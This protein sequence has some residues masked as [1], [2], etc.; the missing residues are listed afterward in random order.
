MSEISGL[1]YIPSVLVGLPKKIAMRRYTV[2]YQ[3][4]NFCCEHLVHNKRV[5][6]EISAHCKASKFYFR[7]KEIWRTYIHIVLLLQLNEQWSQC[8]LKNENWHCF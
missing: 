8:S 2:I 5:L 6:I 4:T 7:Q 3:I 1:E